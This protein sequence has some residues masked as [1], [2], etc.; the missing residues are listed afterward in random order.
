MTPMD[1]RGFLRSSTSSALLASISG[2]FIRDSMGAGAAGSSRALAAANPFAKDE[3]AAR[4]ERVQAAMAAAGYENLIV[5]QRSAATY[6]KVGNVYWLTDFYTDGTGQDPLSQDNDENWTFAAV[7]IRK[8]REPELHIGLTRDEIDASRIVCGKLV[9]H[10]GHMTIKLAEYL[11]AERIE[12]RVA[13]VGDDVLPGMFDRILRSHTP[14]IEWVTE[15]TL[16]EGPQMIKSPQ[17]LEIYRTAGVLVTNALTSATE[18]MIAGE[19]ACEAAARAAAILMRGGGGFHR[20]SIAHG[21]AS[22]SPLSYDY[23]GYNMSAPGAG[24]LITVWIYG[25]IFAGYWMDPGRSTICGRRPPAAQRALVER[26][27][28][29][30]TDMVKVIAPGMTARQVGIRWAEIARKGNYLEEL[31][32]EGGGSMF[33]HGLGTS[34]PAYVLPMGDTETGPYGYKCLKGPLKPGMVLT[35]EAFLSRP[36]VGA[37]GFENNFIVTDSGAELLDKT[38]MVF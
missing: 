17:E 23:Y 16:L 7:L 6:D 36:G 20:I 3:Y 38:P 22:Q 2:G 15:E 18:A 32:G 1:R 24:D 27:A 10:T 12:G 11:R 13:V 31:G 30:V 35:A 37:T 21:P 5:W 26:C 25:P 4:W 8:G 29:L 9:I 19:P 14:Q 28:T 34:F 33:G